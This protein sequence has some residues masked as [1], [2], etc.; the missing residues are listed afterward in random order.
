MPHDDIRAVPHDLER[1]MQTRVVLEGV[2]F[3]ATMVDPDVQS[4]ALTTSRVPDGE[5]GR[6]EHLE[7][8]VITGGTG[9]RIDLRGCIAL[10]HL[11]VSHVRGLT[12]IVGLE[13]LTGLEELDLYALPRIE[14]VP[15]LDRLDR[16]WRL[17][18]GSMKGVTTGLAPFLAAPQLREIQL[19]STF[20]IAPGDAELVRDHPRVVGFSWFDAKGIGAADLRHLFETAGRRRALMRRD[21]RPPEHEVPA[22]RLSEITPTHMVQITV[23]DRGEAGTAVGHPI[24]GIGDALLDG[25]HDFGPGLRHIR[26]SLLHGDH[27]PATSRVKIQQGKGVLAIDYPSEL[28]TSPA[29]F[30]R[31]AAEVIAAL[32]TARA[33]VLEEVPEFSFDALLERCRGIHDRMPATPDDVDALIERSRLQATTLR[34]AMSRLREQARSV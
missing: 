6:L 14:S 22:Q 34:V 32:E 9:E 11:T 3:D 1:W 4:L 33:R 19:Q 31:G 23:T 12:E 7:S 15:S 18:L 20:P 29:A 28:A 8:L 17:D 24:T 21:G 26:V 2:T 30:E 27:R 25:E 16:L 10:R 13:E 5:L